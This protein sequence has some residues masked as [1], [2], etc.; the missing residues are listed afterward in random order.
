MQHANRRAGIRGVPLSWTCWV[1][2]AFLASW[3][4]EMLAFGGQLGG[5]EYDVAERDAAE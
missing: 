4:Q 1:K 2:V 5:A 3:R